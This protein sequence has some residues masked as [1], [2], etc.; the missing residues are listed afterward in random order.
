[1]CVDIWTQNVDGNML[2][3]NLIDLPNQEYFRIIPSYPP[4]N[5]FE[6][7]VDPSEM[8]TLW[9]IESLTNE[10][11]LEK[12][13]NIF[14]IIPEDCVSGPGSS[15][16]MAAF[17]LIDKSQ[18]T[19][20]SDGSYGVYYAA[21][22]KETALRETVYHKEKF[23]KYTN[24]SPF[25]LSMDLYKGT[26]L[27]P[28]HDIREEGYKILHDPQNYVDSQTFGKHLRDKK[29]WGII[30]HSVR[31]PNGVCVACFRPPAVSIPKQISHLKYIW[32]GSRIT[33]VLVT[34]SILNFL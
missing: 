30:Y 23:L 13:G 27:K 11:L 12:T 25:D 2:Q 20:F 7:I 1:M 9:E 21:F 14:R 19:R 34:R 17:T 29:S 5:F 10:R 24:E 8:Q 32:N 3:P 26:L 28:L 16:V 4:I 22:S 15:V 6:D 18:P 33:E 31:H